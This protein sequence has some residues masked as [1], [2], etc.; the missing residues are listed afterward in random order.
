MRWQI[1]KIGGSLPLGAIYDPLK[2]IADI[3]VVEETREAVIARIPYADACLAALTVR[4]DRHILE[5][6]TRLRVIAFPATG[7][8]HIDLDCAAE[9]GIAILSL[10]EDTQFLYEYITCTAEMAWALMLAMVRR[11]PW[12]FEAAKEGRWRGEGLPRGHQVSGMTLG[13]IGYGRLGRIMAEYG[14]AFRMR[15]LASDTR[16]VRATDGVTMVDLDTLLAEADVISL[17]IHLQGNEGFFDQQ[18]FDKIKPGAVLVNTSRGGII[19]ERAFIE[20]LES[21]RL[22]GAGIDVIDG[23]WESD[24]SQHSLIRYAREHQNLIITPHIGG[25]TVE[26]QAL[27]MEHTLN[28]L[29]L[30]L[31]KAQLSAKG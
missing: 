31:E 10:K 24:L 14:Q 5:L 13:I 18:V 4:L 27:T 17:H 30:F 15:V 21:G 7:R 19:D 11:L 20:A 1:L 16:Q 25:A 22:A 29:I 23:E 6:A 2:E 3:T 26:A 12:A 8:D 9:R 28:K